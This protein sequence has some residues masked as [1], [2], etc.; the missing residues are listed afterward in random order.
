MNNRFLP[1]DMPTPR[2]VFD[3]PSN[4]WA[5]LTTPR[6][7]DFEGQQFDRKE[8]CRPDTQG[9]VSASALSTFRQDQVAPTIS[10]FANSS[11]GGGL[12]VLGI[13]KDGVVKGLR[14]LSESQRASLGNID[15][16]LVHHNASVTFHSCKDAEGHDDAIALV[17]VP[18]QHSAICETLS[19]PPRAWK[20]QGPQTLRLSDQHREQIRRDKG[21]VSFERTRCATF[22][23][24]ELDMGV[25]GEYRRSRL[26]DG[27]SSSSDAELLYAVGA[28]A[29]E[30]DETFYTNAGSLFF[31]AN[32]QRVFPA[33]SI[34]LLRF[35]VKYEDRERRGLHTFERFF[36][37]P[38]TQQIRA[39]RAFIQ[40]SGFF[41][42]Y[43]RRAHGGGFV[44][45]PELPYIA[46]DEAVVN[47][48]VH[49]DYAIGLPV[50]CE[51]YID[52]LVVTS[53]GPMLQSAELPKEFSL[54]STR[55]EHLPRNPRLLDWMRSMRDA[56]GAAFVRA[57]SEGT[58]RMR[59]EM[60]KLHLPAPSYHLHDSGTSVC[61]L[62]NADKREAS[63]REG[64]ENGSTEFAN[65][66]ELRLSSGDKSV[67]REQA[68]QRRR[69]LLQALA[70]KLEACGWYI[71]R[72]RYGTLTAHRRGGQVRLPEDVRHSVAFYPAYTFQ[73]REYWNR[74]YLILDY[75]LTVQNTL[76][77]ADLL[78][79]VEAPQLEG[80]TVVAKWRGWQKGKLLEVGA[81]TAKVFLF[82]FGTEETIPLA[83][84]IPKLGRGLVET[85]LKKRRVAF[86]L[87]KEIKRH[88]LSAQPHAS[89]VRAERTQAIANELGEKVFPLF[90]GG[91]EVELRTTPAQLSRRAD[92]KSSLRIESLSE[93]EVAFNQQRFSADIREGIT[94]FGAY[95]FKPKTVEL[96]PI[97]GL[98]FRDNM[99]QLIE[100][101]RGGK[102]KYRGAERTFSTR[103]TNTTTVIAAPEEAA[104]ECERLLQHHPEWRGNTALDRLFLIHVP[105]AAYA[106]DDERSPYYVCKRLLFEAGIPCQM[107]DSPTL[108]NPDYKDL[109]LALNIA[110]KTG[111]A[112]W[113]L[114]ESIPD[115]DFFVGLSYTQSR[116][117]KGERLMGFANV[118]NRFGRWEFYS[119]TSESFAFEERA[120]NYGRLVTDT[121]SR[122]QL[123]DDPTICFHYSAK[124]SHDDRAAILRAA[125]TVK[126]RGR[127]VF[128][129]IN[130]DHSVRLYDSRPESDGSLARGSFVAASPNQ[131]Y[132]STTGFNPYR[133]V[134][135]APHPLEVNVHVE[136]PEGQPRAQLDLRAYAAQVLSLTKLNWA[137]TDSLC[138]EPITTKYAGDIAYLTA[139]F[140]RHGSPFKLHPALERTPWF[141]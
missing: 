92:G 121:L 100:R 74:T 55:L 8:V 76:S 122:L 34:R 32:P 1:S 44:E 53:P 104:T 63:L 64:E 4:H 129:W 132:L 51:K 61:L 69:D 45:E 136:V 5:F 134:L 118:F 116:R 39:F 46:V 35:D 71:D 14:H 108:R 15:Q 62:S 67:T 95:S 130:T 123:P 54:N 105:E 101:L 114:P 124:F 31:V 102:F 93:P 137:S 36:A 109:N 27:H 85:V 47:A 117:D 18:Y 70:M 11:H 20:R 125:R 75:T 103:L 79:Y 78:T 112:P 96:V 115:A 3:S 90:A 33:A 135:G 58:R 127:Y 126:P 107:V 80:L 13:A 133:K 17:Y 22:D 131:F 42:T 89:R 84:V 98:E 68:S 26:S 82:D 52:A 128:V 9:A 49:R 2:D 6:D 56:T 86:D 83:D 106:L 120:R 48:V 77:A 37:G 30:R 50:Q 91:V 41:K 24:A 65:L 72:M 29:R 81:E 94:K 97:C 88:S 57:L 38:L 119:G 40:E 21:I 23:P 28:I 12:L 140:R 138:A 10:A 16:L 99:R 111:V 139:A 19:Q 87:A 7:T 43:Q 141:I 110:A 60:E 25:L 59:E 66:Y 73:I 113:V